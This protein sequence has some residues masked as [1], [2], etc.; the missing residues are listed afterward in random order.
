[1]S[2]CTRCQ[3]HSDAPAAPGELN[4]QQAT[5]TDIENTNG[6]VFNM[7]ACALGGFFGPQLPFLMQRLAR[8]GIFSSW[9]GLEPV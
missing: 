9:G 4:F 6:M 1:M 5:R 2:P 3:G 8:H 7:T